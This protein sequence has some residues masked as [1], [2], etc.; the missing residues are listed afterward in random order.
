MITL[1]QLKRL[2]RVLLGDSY[3]SHVSNFYPLLKEID[4]PRIIDTLHNELIRRKDQDSALYTVMR[5]IELG[6]GDIGKLM[7]LAI[8]LAMKWDD[9]PNFKGLSISHVTELIRVK[10]VDLEQLHK[11]VL[12][13]KWS[14]GKKISVLEVLAKRPDADF[15]LIIRQIQKLALGD[16]AY[17]DNVIPAYASDTILSIRRSWK[18]RSKGRT[19]PKLADDNQIQRLLDL[20]KVRAV[21]DS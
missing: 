2:K 1:S 12:N 16:P 14:V 5:A 8:E 20:V 9:D 18:F 19:D 7:G 21:Q 4:D 11:T 10:N 13:S 3:E 6:K 15:E 17:A